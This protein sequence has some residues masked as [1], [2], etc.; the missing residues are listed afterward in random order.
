M[1][2][3]ELSERLWPFPGRRAPLQQLQPETECLTVG[4]KVLQGE[5]P[6]R[7]RSIQPGRLCYIS[8]G[9]FEVVARLDAK[10]LCLVRQ[11]AGVVIPAL[12]CP[13]K[14]LTPSEHKTSPMLA[15]SPHP[16]LD[17]PSGNEA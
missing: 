17:Q 4:T 16:Q 8:R 3:E 2:S 5:L 12:K 1:P 10:G 14:P 13:A 7:E 9:A 6:F 15:L 11:A